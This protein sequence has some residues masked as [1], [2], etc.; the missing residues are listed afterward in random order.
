MRTRIT[1]L[2][3][4]CLTAV[5]LAAAPVSAGAARP[6][7]IS[8]HIDFEAATEEFTASGAFCS[9]G[10]A[11]ATDNRQTGNRTAVFHV[12]RTFTCADGSGTLSISLDAVFQNRQG[13]TVGGWRIVGGTGAYAGAVGAGHIV[14][15]GT[16]VGIDDLYTGMIR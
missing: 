2:V 8:L 6:V 3:I 1:S 5:V 10:T 13:G 12:D 7:T 15:T 11:V 14:G 16:D 4:G 9:S